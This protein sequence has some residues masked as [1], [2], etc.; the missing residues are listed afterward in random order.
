M[1]SSSDFPKGRTE[2]ANYPMGQA[3]YAHKGLIPQVV[4]FSKMSADDR[5]AYEKNKQNPTNSENYA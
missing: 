2:D 4:D 3:A 1:A 5:A